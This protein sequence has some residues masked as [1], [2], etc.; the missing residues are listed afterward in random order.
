MRKVEKYIEVITRALALS[1]TILE[2]IEHIQRTLEEIRYEDATVLIHDVMEGLKAIEEAL[3]PLVNELVDNNLEYLIS[4]LK[5]EI[6]EIIDLFNNDRMEAAAER[7]SKKLIP[8]FTI[9]KQELHR[10]IGPF[11]L[12]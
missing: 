9:W 5:D 8:A 11:V 7:T 6:E 12:Q 2:G 3:Q 10:V 4:N 1:D